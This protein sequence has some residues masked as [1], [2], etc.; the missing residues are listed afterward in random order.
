MPLTEITE[1][2]TLSPLTAER[3]CFE[4]HYPDLVR[5]HLGEVVLIHGSNILGFFKSLPEAEDAAYREHGLFGH[6]FL[7]R[8]IV[9]PEKE[10]RAEVCQR[11]I[12]TGLA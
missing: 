12:L 8:A 11:I 6:A 10:K 9:T 5:K 1:T 4:R 7:L 3:L 2:E